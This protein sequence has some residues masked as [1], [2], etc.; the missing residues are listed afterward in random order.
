MIVQKLILRSGL[1]VKV[2]TFQSSSIVFGTLMITLTNCNQDN[3]S[4]SLQVPVCHKMAC[5]VVFLWSISWSLSMVNFDIRMMKHEGS[6]SIYIIIKIE[7]RII[8][9]LYHMDLS[10]P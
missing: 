10:P 2:S 6:P 5:L 3:K 1:W 7:K 8:M 9:I 4:T